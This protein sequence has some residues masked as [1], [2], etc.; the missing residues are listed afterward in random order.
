MWRRIAGQERACATD[1]CSR[2]PSWCLDVDGVVL[3]YCSRCKEQIEREAHMDCYQY[4][5]LPRYED[6]DMCPPQQEM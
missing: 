5:T 3:V 1:T 2:E 6:E 4:G